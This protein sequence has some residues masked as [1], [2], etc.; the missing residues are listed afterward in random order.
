MAEGV[1][2]QEVTGQQPLLQDGYFL[3]LIAHEVAIGESIDLLDAVVFECLDDF[4]SYLFTTDSENMTVMLR[5]IINRNGHFHWPYRSAR[6][7][8]TGSLSMRCEQ[9]NCQSTQ[10][11]NHD[12]NLVHVWPFLGVVHGITYR[13]AWSQVPLQ[14]E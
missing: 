13:G 4:M 8:R 2:T 7:K 12:K 1:V 5:Q 14:S 10:Q 6:V 3:R 11:D 9:N